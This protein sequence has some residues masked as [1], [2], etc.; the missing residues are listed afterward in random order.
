MQVLFRLFTLVFFLIPIISN[1]QTYY[2]DNYSVKQGLSQSTVRV[3]FQDSEGYVWLGTQSGVSRFDGVN[4]I[5]YNVNDGLA[6]NSVRSIIEDS[7]G[8][9]WLGHSGGGISKFQNDTFK[10]IKPDTFEITSD[11]T[12]IVR[13]YNGNIWFATEKNGALRMTNA[14]DDTKEN[15]FY[16]YHGEEGLSDRVFQIHQGI[17]NEIFFIT[18]AGIKLYESEVDSFRPVG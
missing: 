2:F 4:F 16:S 7:T 9:L 12:S 3:T 18:D 5:N 17:D 13:D 10:V 1:S 6:G 14:E 8:A 15:N 11:V